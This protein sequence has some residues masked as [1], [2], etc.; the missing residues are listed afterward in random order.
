VTRRR[1][2][3]K[4]DE[5]KCDGCGLCVPACA[6]GAI[7]VIDGKARLISEVYCDGLGACL[8]EC[9]QGAIT[10]EEREAAEFDEEE[11]RK[12]MEKGS[13]ADEPLE[14]LPKGCP[15]LAFAKL[16]PG[17]APQAKG[18]GAAR[19]ESGLGNWP[20]QLRLVPPG[21]PFLRGADILVSADC[22]PFCVADFHE[23]YLKGR[24]V[25]VGCPK[26]DDL[27]S[28]RGKLREIF[29]EARPESITVLRMEVPCCAGIAAA[30][31][32]A[33]DRALPERPV[34]ID[35]I[36]IRGEI[37]EEVSAPVSLREEV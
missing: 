3:V 17:A 21:A 20:V 19:E 18:T 33:R 32:E 37:R 16:R 36:G 35:T 1:K 34:R 9:P 31:V 26:L 4:I 12:H 10:I 13:R 7:Q 25:L 15:G 27:E 24:V 11:V 6:E 14:D 28:Y 29:S 30:V 5:E 23:R 8:G 2:I 22:V